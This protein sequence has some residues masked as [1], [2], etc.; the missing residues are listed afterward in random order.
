MRSRA[1]GAMPSQAIAAAAHAS[2]PPRSASRNAAWTSCSAGIVMF[3]LP[4]AEDA[5]GPTGFLQ[6]DR[7]RRDVGVPL[8][9]GRHGADA[10]DRVTIQAPDL[11][12]DRRTVVIDQDGL[13]VGVIAR[14]AGQMHFL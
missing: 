11:Q 13:P 6:Q 2:S 1:S 8:D 10:R 7:E 14:V 4:T 5:L 9:Q 3:R 12:R